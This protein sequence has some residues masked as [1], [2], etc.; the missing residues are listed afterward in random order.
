MAVEECVEPYFSSAENLDSEPLL[1]PL[2][3][4]NDLSESDESLGNASRALAASFK[5]QKE[6]V[7]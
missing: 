2:P 1:W 3:L 4:P 6:K 5:H 7:F